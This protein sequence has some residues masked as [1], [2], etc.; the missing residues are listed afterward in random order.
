LGRPFERPHFVVNA[1]SPQARGAV[2]LDALHGAVERLFPGAGWSRT[3]GPGDAAALARAAAAGGAD[4]IVAVG[5]D[6]TINE[7]ANGILTA[8][9]DA[10]GSATGESARVTSGVTIYC[11]S[12]CSRC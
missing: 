3:S 6:G 5:G 9:G 10:S 2:R 1:R 7:V 12:V 4:L 11:T 8:R